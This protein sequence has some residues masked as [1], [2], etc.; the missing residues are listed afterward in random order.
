MCVVDAMNDAVLRN[1]FQDS[2]QRIYADSLRKKYVNGGYS[3][4]PTAPVQNGQVQNSY[5]KMN[6]S[7]NP[8]SE[9]DMHSLS[10]G[11]TGQQYHQVKINQT[12]LY[13]LSQNMTA[14]NTR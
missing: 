3:A 14:V 10:N 13:D 4:V 12:E 9:M 7:V 11:H 2:S 6:V 5:T 8:L 1:K